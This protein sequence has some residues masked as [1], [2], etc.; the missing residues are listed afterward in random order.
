MF[1]FLYVSTINHTNVENKNKRS[2]PRLVITKLKPSMEKYCDLRKTNSDHKR[3]NFPNVR[4]VVPYYRVYSSTIFHFCISIWF[5]HL[6]CCHFSMLNT[7]LNLGYVLESPEQILN[8]WCF[9]NKPELSY[10]HLKKKVS[11]SA[12]FK[13]CR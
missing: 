8:S 1:L 11:I 7:T 3:Y 4:C 5:S 9:S 10:Q 6:T 2:F 13:S 12:M